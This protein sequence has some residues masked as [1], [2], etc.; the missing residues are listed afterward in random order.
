MQ[1]NARQV[2]RE[3]QEEKRLTWAF[4]ERG[5]NGLYRRIATVPE[6]QLA[7]LAPTPHSSYLTISTKDYLGGSS[8]FEPAERA[9]AQLEILPG[10]RHLV[11]VALF[12]VVAITGNRYCDPVPTYIQY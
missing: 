5:S 10:A 2:S 7:P 9:I 6:L 8:T 4:E 1:H 12:V 11:Q 3:T